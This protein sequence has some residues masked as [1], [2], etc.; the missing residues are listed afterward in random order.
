MSLISFLILF[1]SS[2]VASNSFVIT[3]F[4]VLMKDLA[5]SGYVL[6]SKE[7]TQT[8]NIDTE[9]DDSKL[10]FLLMILPRRTV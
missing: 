6:D 3:M 8:S 5:E 9:S 10:H 2:L 7:T 4:I 1:F